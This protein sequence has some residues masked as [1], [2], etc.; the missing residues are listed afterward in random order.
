M[1]LSVLRKA[2]L[3]WSLLVLVSE[4]I[5]VCLVSTGEMDY[6][7]AS[8]ISKK[9]KWN[10]EMQQMQWASNETLQSFG[11]FTANAL[12]YSR[13]RSPTKDTTTCCNLVSKKMKT[14]LFLQATWTTTLQ[15]LAFNQI[16][17]YNVTEAY[18]I[19]NARTAGKSLTQ[20]LMKSDSTKKKRKQKTS[21][22]ARNVTIMFGQ[23]FTCPMTT[24]GWLNVHKS[25]WIGLS[26]GSVKT[27][28]CPLL[29]SK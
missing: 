14:T 7:T 2:K 12:T 18:S 8:L 21:L 11:F 16:A 9:Q 28:A 1:Q 22:N 20:T 19:Y 4:L 3:C 15:R 24:S 17:L 23:T 5:Q 13:V 29:S 6:R 25:K 27:K 10:L 26:A